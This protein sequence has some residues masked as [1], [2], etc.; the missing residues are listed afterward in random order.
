MRTPTRNLT[1]LLGLL[2]AALPAHAQSPNTSAIAVVV[3]DQQGGVVPAAGV[4]V[5]NTATGATRTAST[6]D[7]GA[8]AF[9]ALPLTGSYVVTIDKPGFAGEERRDIGLRAGE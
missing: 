1:L 4:T 3:L 9:A 8:A 5:T 2:L 6:G 7:D